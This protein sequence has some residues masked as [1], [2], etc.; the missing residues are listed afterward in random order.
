MQH[1]ELER[2]K[3]HGFCCRLSVIVTNDNQPTVA[4]MFLHD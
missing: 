4:D 1:L 3:L 2:E